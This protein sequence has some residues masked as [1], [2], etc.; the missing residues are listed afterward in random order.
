MLLLKL[1]ELF[2]LGARTGADLA[3]HVEMQLSLNFADRAV[4]TMTFGLNNNFPSHL[5]NNTVHFFFHWLN[6]S[7]ASRVH[8]VLGIKALPK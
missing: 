8:L 6:V 5:F 7:S 1:A 4:G 3:W 2:L